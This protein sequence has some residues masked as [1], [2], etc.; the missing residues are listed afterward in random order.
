MQRNEGFLPLQIL[1][2]ERDLGLGA[3]KIPLGLAKR[4]GINRRVNFRDELAF[5]HRRVEVNIQG[6]DFPGNLAA[7][8]HADH[9][10]ERSAGGDM[11]HDVPA[12]DQ[13]GFVFERAAAR[14]FAAGV[15]HQRERRERCRQHAGE[16]QVQFHNF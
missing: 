11:L 1:V 13:R 4:G 2:L 14:F 3:G 9:G 15:D 8:V 12:R 16:F 6:D 7:H 5:F 10:A